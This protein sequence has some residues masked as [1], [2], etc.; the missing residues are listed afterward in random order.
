MKNYSL[1]WK[2]DVLDI[3]NNLS[4]G[5]Y[6]FYFYSS[7]ARNLR[8]KI[9][10]NFYYILT[11]ANL[12]ELSQLFE[13]IEFPGKTDY[14]G[15][16][17]CKEFSIRLKICDMPYD[18]TD[19][20]IL[21][22]ESRKE[23]FTL[24]TIFFDIKKEIFLD[25]LDCYYDFR[26][27]KIKLTPDFE[28]IY[29]DKPY[30]IFDILYLMSEYDFTLEEGIKCKIEKIPFKFR[31]E[32]SDEIIAGFNKI[33][34]TKNPYISISIMD[35]LNILEE[36][37]PVLS[38]TKSVPQNKDFH[39]E[40]NVYEHTIECFKYLRKPSLPLALSLLL[41]DTGKPETLTRNGKN[42]R[43]PGHSR[44]GASIARKI[45]RKFGYSQDIIG[46]VAF[47]IE[48]H[49]LAHEFRHMNEHQK[50]EIINNNMFTDLLK[51]YK[52]D[53]SSCYG[54][55]IDYKKIVSLYK[56]YKK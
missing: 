9:P 17:K 14:D 16:I 48:Y 38:D 27:K 24:N 56:K 54:D 8:L 28:E 51:L 21:R 44:A 39:P 2:K 15:E 55:L 31:N 50:I 41:H 37:F 32:Y 1:F 20:D 34:V 6:K 11:T 12:I 4:E 49:L 42:L 18:R 19:F 47:L 3:C 53:V 22:Q 29:T 26:E 52:A 10:E 5:G 46:K 7:T 43:F 36:I 33:I 40:G 25:P 13:S 35:K 30:K 23:L 45:L